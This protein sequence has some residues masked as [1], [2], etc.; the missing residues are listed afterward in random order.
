ML[1]SIK[2]MAAVIPNM[3]AG[4][5]RQGFVDLESRRLIAWLSDYGRSTCCSLHRYSTF[6]RSRADEVPST[7]TPGY[8]GI[9]K[10]ALSIWREATASP[11]LKVVWLIR[12]HGNPVYGG[13]HSGTIIL[14]TTRHA[15][16]VFKLFLFFEQTLEMS[17][18]VLKN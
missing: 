9:Y 2:P 1:R 10:Q 15:I 5:A 3:F 6:C 12:I 4:L 13:K 17:N 7:K 8:Q 11:D 14:L 18:S 16:M